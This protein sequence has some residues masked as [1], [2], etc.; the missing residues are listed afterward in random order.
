MRPPRSDKVL[1]HINRMA[2]GGLQPDLTLLLDLPVSLGLERAG[3]RNQREGTVLSEGRFDAES[4]AYFF[5]QPPR[6]AD[7]GSAMNQYVPTAS[8]QP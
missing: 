1:R 8:C 3:L 6:F 4:L 2:T 7:R 5:D